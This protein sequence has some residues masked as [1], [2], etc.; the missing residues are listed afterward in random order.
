LFLHI[1]SPTLFFQ[2]LS[3]RAQLVHVKKGAPLIRIGD[4]DC[5]LVFV[6]SGSVGISM[7]SP[8]THLFNV[9]ASFFDFLR[10]MHANLNGAQ[11]GPGQ[12]CGELSILSDGESMINAKAMEDS[13]VLSI[14]HNVML[15]LVLPQ[16]KPPLH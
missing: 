5:N 14:P 10:Y 3:L 13:I 11:I 16:K 12:M 9:G 8:E 1:C 2:S 4:R 6:V 15:A 7:D